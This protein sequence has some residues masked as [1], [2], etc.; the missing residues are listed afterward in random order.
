MLRKGTF[1]DFEELYEIYMHPSVNPY[2][3]FEIMPAQE[4]RPIFRELTNG[5][6]LYI[7]EL[8]DKIA[9]T[10]IIKKLPRRCQHVALLGTLATHP[11]LHGKGIGTIFMQELINILKKEKFKRIELSL[12]ADN[13]IGEKFYHKLGFRLEGTLKN[14]FKREH[15]NHYVDEHIMAML[16]D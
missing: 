3:S 13:L 16:L 12:E 15:E 6:D 1:S 10:C 7:Y 14:W 2:L 5:N 11:S 8:E 4:F 9:S